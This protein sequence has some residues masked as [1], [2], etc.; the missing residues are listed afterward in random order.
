VNPGGYR[1]IEKRNNLK[2]NIRELQSQSE[3]SHST[4]MRKTISG[5]DMSMAEEIF[6]S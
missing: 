2:K 6:Q 5:S 3:Y 1:N 4:T